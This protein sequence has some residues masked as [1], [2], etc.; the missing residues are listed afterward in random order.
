MTNDFIH[1]FLPRE[2]AEE[3]TLLMLHGTGGDENSL[4]PLGQALLPGAA[5]LS[6]CGRIQEGGSARFFRR[7]SEGVFDLDNLT[8]E[9]AALAAFVAA[10]AIAHGFD[11]AKVVAIGF[12]NGANIGHSLM[13]LH[14]NTISAGVFIRAMTTFPDW[15]PAGLQGR[16]ALIS[17]GRTDP[18]VPVE[19]ANF[20]A[21][22]LRQ[23]GADVVHHWVDAGHD[24]TRGELSVIVDWLSQ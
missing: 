10:S 14:P 1:R 9:A 4:I 24:L 23:G 15:E 11:P 6:P 20:L 13:A 21:E 7:F 16:R 18:L 19:D 22:Q 2:S 3:R 17:S 5:I 8:E 12:S